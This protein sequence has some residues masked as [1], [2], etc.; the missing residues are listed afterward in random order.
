MEYARQ[1]P[2]ESVE[3]DTSSKRQRKHGFVVFGLHDALKG[4]YLAIGVSSSHAIE[5]THGG[6]FQGL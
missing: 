2:D 4:L 3:V 5:A 1:L 6:S